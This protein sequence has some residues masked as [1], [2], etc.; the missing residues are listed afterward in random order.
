LISSSCNNAINTRLQPGAKS[1]A[2]RSRFNGFLARQKTVETVSVSV[3]AH[4]GLK[5]GV[6]K[7]SGLIFKNVCSP[8]RTLP[9][10]LPTTL[11]KTRQLLGWTFAQCAVFS[12]GL[13]SA[14][15]G[16][17]GVITLQ[18]SGDAWSDVKQQLI[19]HWRKR[20]S[21]SEVQKTNTWSFTLMGP[22]TIG[23]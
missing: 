23:S 10:S 17:S 22:Q 1:K 3:V 18:E 5:P 7:N 15:T 8:M 20:P 14:G 16:G 19:G 6:N 4:T 9:D 12:F 11:M 2:N 13:V 21:F